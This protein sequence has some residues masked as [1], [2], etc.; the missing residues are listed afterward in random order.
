MRLLAEFR[1]Y[2]VDISYSRLQTQ[3]LTEVQI[4]VV[5]QEQ[6]TFYVSS[7]LHLTHGFREVE[8]TATFYQTNYVNING[9]CGNGRM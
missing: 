6:K 7:M 8:P 3:Y 4:L 9:V 2:F 5:T 1:F